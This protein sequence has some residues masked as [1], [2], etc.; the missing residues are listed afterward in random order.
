MNLSQCLMNRDIKQ[1]AE[2]ATVYE[3]DCNRHSKLEL[4][5]SIHYAMRSKQQLHQWMESVDEAV[6]AY[7]TYLL[8][9]PVK[10]FDMNEL[11][12]KARFVADVFRWKKSYKKWVKDLIKRGWLFPV[13]SAYHQQFHFPEDFQ[14]T[15]K[16]QLTAYWQSEMKAVY[17]E[18]KRLEMSY[19]D[20]KGAIENDL[21]T[22]LQFV[23]EQAIVLTKDGVIHKRFQR[24]IM[25]RFSVSE[26]LIEG[27]QWRFG[28][29]RRFPA[30]PNRLALIYDYC[31]D[32]GWINE[33]E[34]ML[35]VTQ[36]G[37]KWLE[38]AMARSADAQAQVH[39][40]EQAQ[41]RHQSG[42]ND[43]SLN[44]VRDELIRYWI[45]TYRQAIPT[46]PFL[47]SWLTHTFNGVWINSE[48][49]FTSIKRWIQ[50]YYFDTTEA[51]YNERLLQMMCHLGLLHIHYDGSNH[52]RYMKIVS[53]K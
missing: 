38:E 31:F 39:S 12:S 14:R 16:Q 15:L 9:Q 5:Q 50:P 48:T 11:L 35:A 1:L 4:V 42:S 17:C 27:K 19:R 29:G 10:T 46:L 26:E 40:F 32:Q 23:R 2:L 8:F 34:Q 7:Y 53:P 33:S 41:L 30:Y 28:Y 44:N 36:S 6:I 22:F 25:Q 20:E 37:V 51:I 18:N 43:S 49:L 3:C 47:Y 21:L 24:Q 45:K 13:K 52:I